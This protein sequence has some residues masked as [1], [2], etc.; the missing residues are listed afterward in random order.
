MT[1]EEAI[2][3]AEE[4]A[5]RPLD[6]AAAMAGGVQV[7]QSATEATRRPPAAG[8]SAPSATAERQAALRVRALYRQGRAGAGVGGAGGAGTD[9][10]GGGGGGKARRWC[11][12]RRTRRRGSNGRA[13]ALGRGWQA[14]AATRASPCLG[15]LPRR[16]EAESAVARSLGKEGSKAAAEKEAQRRRRRR[17]SLRAEEALA[18]AAAEV[19]ALAALRRR[20]ARLPRHLR[21]S[22][23]IWTMKKPLLR[24]PDRK[25]LGNYVTARARCARRARALGPEGAPRGEGG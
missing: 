23:Q 12:R 24:I 3:A 8:T 2:A 4:A 1:A 19:L 11:A 16:R 5:A 6:D 10:G 7:Q 18:A 22:I 21:R 13:D 14:G 15:L 25:S 20:P 9:G 17:R